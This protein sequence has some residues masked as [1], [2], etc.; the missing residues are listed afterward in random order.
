MAG[1]I[2]VGWDECWKQRGE[3]TV[4]LNGGSSHAADA[5]A[6]NPWPRAKGAEVPISRVLRVDGA[7]DG[8]DDG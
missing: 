1:W 5:S 6:G 7:H 3:R 2:T 8:P 4:Q